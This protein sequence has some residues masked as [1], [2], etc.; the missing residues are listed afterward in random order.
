VSV[1]ISGLSKSYGGVTALHPLE[2]FVERG[3]LMVVVGPSASGKTTLLRCI[4]GLELPER[5]SIA[6][7]GRDVTKDPPGQRE[8]AM[9]FQE[10]ALYPHLTVE[11]NISVGM[12]ARKTDR[13]EV[14]RRVAE[15]SDLLGLGDVLERHPGELSGGERQRV[16][17]AR[18][19]VR[20]PSVFLLDEPLSNLDAELRARTRAQIKTL[21]Q[22]LKTSMIYVTHDQIEAMGL[23]DRIA[24]LRAG[25][26]QQTGRPRELWERP[27]NGFVAR[28]IGSPPMN[29][30]PAD[31]L[32]GAAHE[33]ATVL[34]LRP[35]TIRMAPTKEGR[36]TGRVTAVEPAGPD[37]VV[38][39]D[40]META[41]VVVADWAERPEVGEERGLVFVDDDVYE[42]DGFE[43]RLLRWGRA[44]LSPGLI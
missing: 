1:E 25:R 2:L 10:F 31:M 32:S 17:L 28:F 6:V 23:G 13:G 3:E 5:G 35:H 36:L 41:F 34:G 37:A 26:I 39:L 15:A 14:D 12:R 20:E 24:V 42:F 27:A 38:H 21:Q 9:V 40:V 18:A 8:V 33:G 19:I 44:A 4:A 22:R 16:A 11:R 29:L 7:G 43:G 30:F